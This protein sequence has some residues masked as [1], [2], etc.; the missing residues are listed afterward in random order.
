L[1]KSK[2]LIV[3]SFKKQVRHP[4]LLEFVFAEIRKHAS[5]G[6][7][8]I[9]L[10][11]PYPDYKVLKAYLASNKVR[12]AILLKIS[13]SLYIP[14]CILKKESREGRNLSRHSEDFLWPKIVKVQ[15]EIANGRYTEYEL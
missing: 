11:S 6:K 9:D 10:F 8:L 5:G 12:A 15:Q 13:K 4:R 1:L 7:N 2:I 14:F 3:H